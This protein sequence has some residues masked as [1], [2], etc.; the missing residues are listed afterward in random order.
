MV[1]IFF[2]SDDSGLIEVIELT[3]WMYLLSYA[4]GPWD[5]AALTRDECTCARGWTLCFHHAMIKN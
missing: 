2:S 5:L 3:D 4:G 1:A